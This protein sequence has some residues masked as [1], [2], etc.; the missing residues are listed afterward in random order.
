MMK[1]LTTLTAVVALIAGVSIAN[2]ASTSSMGK[3]KSMN[4]SSMSKSARVIGTSKYCIKTKSG[5]LNC[6]FA[7]LSDCQ[8]GAK[9]ATCSA[10]PNFGTTGSK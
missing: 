1:T 10:N 9:G 8:N 6:K 4:S 3:D 5:E 2:A 7:S